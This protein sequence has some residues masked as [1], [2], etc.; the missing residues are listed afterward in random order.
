MLDIVARGY[1]ILIK[2][3][4]IRTEKLSFHEYLNRAN[5]FRLSRR[6]HNEIL[7]GVNRQTAKSPLNHASEAY[8]TSSGK[9]QMAKPNAATGNAFQ[10]RSVSEHEK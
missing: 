2:E 7:S 5:R 1:N 10:R 9:L 3:T 8:V 4:E 6:R